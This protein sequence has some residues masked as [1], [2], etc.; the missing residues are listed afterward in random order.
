MSQEAFDTFYPECEKNATILVD[1]DLVK[2][3]KVLPEQKLYSIPA[4]R[5]AEKLGRKLVL[6]IVMMGFFTAMT[7]IIEED[8]MRKAVLDS[9]PKG[10][11]ALNRKA[12]EEGLKYGKKVLAS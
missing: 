4:T 8:A 12:F 6:N 11:E 5:I 2:T 1:K 3:D 7:N 9:V 10:T